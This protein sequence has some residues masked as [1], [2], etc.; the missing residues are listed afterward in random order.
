MNSTS[1]ILI[2]NNSQLVDKRICQKFNI[3]ICDDSTELLPLL[4]ELNADSN[5][6]L[7][8]EELGIP[9]RVF[10]R[11][12]TRANSYTKCMLI[13]PSKFAFDAW[14]LNVFHFDD[15]PLDEQ[16]IQQFLSKQSQY[17]EKQIKTISF[18]TKEGLLRISFRNILYVKAS[19]N[20]SEFFLTNNKKLVQT[21]QL[22]QCEKLLCDHKSFVRIH[23]SLIINL[24]A[25]QK[26]Y[27]DKIQFYGTD[28]K[29]SA[30]Q[31]LVDK[32]KQNLLGDVR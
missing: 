2:Y 5:I 20:Y 19:G 12:I 27:K 13:A 17:A 3:K 32:I 22:H 8:F 31:K 11:N 7:V 14:K 25:I 10:I 29:L 15:L 16:K 21:K 26:I 30:S 23:R 24:D 6:I 9:Q 28:V 18:K 1:P 4:S